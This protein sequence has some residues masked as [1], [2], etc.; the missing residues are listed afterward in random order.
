VTGKLWQFHMKP[1]R[2][3]CLGKTAHRAWVAGEAVEHEYSHI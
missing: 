1:S 3:A 2:G